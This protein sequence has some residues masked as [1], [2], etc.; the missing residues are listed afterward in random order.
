MLKFIFSGSNIFYSHKRGKIKSNGAGMTNKYS[1]QT[2]IASAA[3]EAAAI[4]KQVLA[5]LPAAETFDYG[6]HALKLGDYDMCTDCTR[7]IA[8][9]QQAYR[10]LVKKAKV[11]EDEILKEHLELAAEFLRLEAKAA[12]IRAELHSGHGSEP[13][14]NELLGFV[15][16]RHVHDKPEH[17]HEGREV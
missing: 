16:N 14:V 12:E 11:Q 17:F 4:I 2:K 7:S 1:E 13:I 3:K 10:A 5:D 8:E 15:Y 9:A 6:G